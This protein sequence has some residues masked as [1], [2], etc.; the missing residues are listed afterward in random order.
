MDEKALKELLAGENLDFRT[1]CEEHLRLE[2]ALEE[3]KLKAS[4]TDEEILRER[5][6]KKKKLVLKDK[7]YRMMSEFG[8]TR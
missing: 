8:K 7:M 6:F 5:E 2:K 3:L 1:V 4:L